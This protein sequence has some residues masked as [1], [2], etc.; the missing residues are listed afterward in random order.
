M[1]THRVNFKRAKVTIK[2]AALN[3]ESTFDT[4]DK[5]AEHEH[6]QHPKSDQNHLFSENSNSPSS[7]PPRKKADIEDKHETEVE[8]ID[9]ELEANFSI[10]ILLENRIK[11][12]LLMQSLN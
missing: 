4:E 2:C 8:M 11:C 6:N 10:Y 1:N 9:L 12:I 7:S 3:C 5:L